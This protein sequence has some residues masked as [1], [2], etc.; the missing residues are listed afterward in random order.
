M[1][2]GLQ[3]REGHVHDCAVD[4]GH[5]RPEDRYR[6]DPVA[7]VNSGS[8]AASG[9]D[10]GFIAWALDEVAHDSFCAAGASSRKTDLLI[11]SVPK[12]SSTRRSRDT[13]SWKWAASRFVESF[14]A[15]IRNLNAVARIALYAKYV[16]CP[17]R[18]PLSGG[19]PR[20][21]ATHLGCGITSSIR[22]VSLMIV[23]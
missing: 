1:Q 16:Q 17:S 23:K 14:T 19:C 4:E 20:V 10:R 8:R 22:Y 12:Q 13:P 5:A 6:E 7:G 9:Q 3:R 15:T 11:A 2:I 18:Y 21:V